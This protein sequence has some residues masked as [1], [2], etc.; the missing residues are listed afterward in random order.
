MSAS[1]V[2]LT[3]SVPVFLFLAGLAFNQPDKYLDVLLK[4]LGKLANIIMLALLVYG[5]SLSLFI[6][7]EK[8]AGLDE[9]I[10]NSISSQM[11]SL[12]VC[13]LLFLS[14]SLIGNIPRF[15]AEFTNLKYK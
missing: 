6:F 10:L 12:E 8:D 7:K 15:I 11:W 14:F 4:P 13:G 1:S 9:E 3:V 5:I 2:I